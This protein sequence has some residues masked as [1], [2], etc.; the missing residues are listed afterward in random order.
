MPADSGNL[1]EKPGLEA[2]SQK[3]P[4]VLW[5]KLEAKKNATSSK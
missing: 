1:M 4:M 2:R 3:S 5:N